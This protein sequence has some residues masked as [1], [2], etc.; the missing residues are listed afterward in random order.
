[1][2][3][4][5]KKN[6]PHDRLII[7]GRYPVPGQTKTRLIPALGPA[8]A[9]DL[10]RELTEKTFKTVR[11]F[12]SKQNIEVEFC[13]NGGSERKIRRWLNPGAI[14]SQQSYG[15]LGERMEAAFKE[16]FRDGCGRV[17][18]LGT[19]IPELGTGHLREAFDALAEHGLVIGPSTDGGY[20]L[21]GLKHTADLFQG[22]DW[23]TE[24]VL[25]QTVAL[26]NRQGLKIH[27]LQ[28]LSDIDT[29]EDLSRWRP[30]ETI[31]SP[32]ISIIIPALN[33]G[34]NIEETINR[35]GSD[36][37]EI[38]VVDGGSSDDTVKRSIMAGA[39][40][41]SS[42][43]GRAAQQ[44]MGAK[45]A[46]GKVLLFLHADT[47]LPDGYVLHIFDALMDPETVVGAFRFKTDL[48]RP[49][50]K[51]IEFVTNIR[52]HYL[53]LPYGDQGLFMRKSVFDSVSGFPQVPIA[54]DLFL[55]R[56]LA[57]RGRVS[58]VPAY[59]VTSARRWR[60]LGLFRTTLVNQII[61]T[62]YY[63]GV[64]PQRLASLY[65]IPPRK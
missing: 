39:R 43:P 42:L 54:E 18:L 5:S 24:K 34:A 8:G 7:F 32:Y 21:I 44:N 29:E 58:I 41:E 47:H 64:S 19:D 35:A 37:T 51:V 49:L 38:I 12:T 60:T 10:H 28:P 50:M 52:S 3:L 9:A 48:N 2:I 36:D 40:V 53:K 61:L 56:M 22:V 1:M 11:C 17:V 31:P 4:S 20:W 15:D 65:R 6:F 46:R 45:Q 33:E 16:A 14:L 59:A 57:K 30:D 26:A 62:G 23:G 55:V 13:F 63:L 27:L 25:D